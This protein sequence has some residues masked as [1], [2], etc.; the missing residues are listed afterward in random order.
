MKPGGV[1]PKKPNIETGR[2]F[3]TKSG[4]KRNKK[5]A[6][7][8]PQTADEQKLVVEGVKVPKIEVQEPNSLEDL[9]QDNEFV[10]V[11]FTENLFKKFRKKLKLPKLKFLKIEH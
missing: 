10:I 8:S 9:E 4:L 2:A 3:F 7:V 5:F 6:N 1:Q 11:R